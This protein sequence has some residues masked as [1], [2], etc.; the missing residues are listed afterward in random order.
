MQ[1]GI[2]EMSALLHSHREGLNYTK[3][4]LKSHAVVLKGYS[5]MQI[6]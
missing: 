3:F 4:L 6:V 1:Y 2:Y 5:V